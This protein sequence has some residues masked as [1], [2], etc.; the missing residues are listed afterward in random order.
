[1]LCE[2]IEEM[3]GNSEFESE[4]HLLNLPKGAVPNHDKK[5]G[6][7]SS[8]KKAQWSRG[9]VHGAAKLTQSLRMLAGGSCMDFGHSC[10][11]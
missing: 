10:N 3:V 5:E 6:L 11:M 7:I 1:M 8:I 4:Q 9:F 2:H